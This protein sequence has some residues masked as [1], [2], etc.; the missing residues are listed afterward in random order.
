MHLLDRLR[1]VAFA[2]PVFELECLDVR[3]QLLLIHILNVRSNR[4]IQLYHVEV[5]VIIRLVVGV[6]KVYD[7]ILVT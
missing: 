4:I 1:I 6:Q 7:C 3:P 2:S 5:V